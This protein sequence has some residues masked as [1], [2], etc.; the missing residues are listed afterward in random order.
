VITI[1]LPF[2]LPVRTAALIGAY[3]Q[4]TIGDNWQIVPG[5]MTEIFGMAE[6][7]RAAHMNRIAWVIDDGMERRRRD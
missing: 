4:R 2:D 7:E 3:L 1:Q 5:Q 6:H